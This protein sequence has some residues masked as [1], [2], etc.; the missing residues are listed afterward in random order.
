[1]PDY[2]IAGHLKDFWGVDFY[3]V[4]DVDH[5]SRL[6]TPIVTGKGGG[7]TGIPLEWWQDIQTFLVDKDHIAVLGGNDNDDYIHTGMHS[8]THIL[9]I[10]KD[11]GPKRM[12]REA[13]GLWTVYD[14]ENGTKLTIDFDLTRRKTDRP[15]S[16]APEL[17]DV[18]ITDFCAYGCPFCY[19]GSTKQGKHM[20]SSKW[21]L[22]EMLVSAQVFEIAIGGGEPTS[23]PEFLEI[24]KL[25][26]DHQITPNFTTRN[27]GL[28]NS[29]DAKQIVELMG[30]CA[31]SAD[32]ALQI[33]AWGETANRFYPHNEHL[34]RLKFVVHIV[35]G[36]QDDAML[37]SM[38]KMAHH[39]DLSCTLLGYKTTGR[40][41]D[42]PAYPYDH[43]LE[44][45]IEPLIAQSECP[46][47]SIDTALAATHAAQLEAMN[48][49]SCLYYVHEGVHSMYLDMVSRSYGISS[50]T[51]DLRSL[52]DLEE[53]EA[54]IRKTDILMS[55]WKDLS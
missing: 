44:T 35:M 41:G 20:Q 32:N 34:K 16:L 42:G 26:R 43:F 7:V 30:G 33:K 29:S 23:H 18:K 21:D 48:I 45:V 13:P 8:K 22:I 15:R 40:G 25:C 51:E 28:F 1:M 31:Y 9:E 36:V 5:Q 2:L 14:P 38:L 6:V 39:Y 3:A 37:M 4:G 10:P 54:L 19:Q 27:M 49:P 11:C 55:A 12:R 24:L 46:Q 53:R 47:F 50:Y 52:R 17:V